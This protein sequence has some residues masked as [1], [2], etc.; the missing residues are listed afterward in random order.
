[1]TSYS[2]G[3]HRERRTGKCRS[4]ADGKLTGA[5]GFEFSEPLP[6]AQST[7]GDERVAKGKTF[8]DDDLLATSRSTTSIRPTSTST[9]Q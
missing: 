4:D 1:M 5:S 8:S 9:A 6:D 2:G 3:R 7:P